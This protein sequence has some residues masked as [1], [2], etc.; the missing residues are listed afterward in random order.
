MDVLGPKT[1]TLHAP[2]LICLAAMP[3]LSPCLALRSA[4]ADSPASPGKTV[5][6]NRIQGTKRLI[7]LERITVGPEDHYQGAPH[8]ASHQLVFTRKIDL[9]PHLA[10]QNLSTGDVSEFVPATADS[11][12]PATHPNGMVAFTYFKFNAR[13]DICYRSLSRP[14]IECLKALEGEKDTP[15]WRSDT[16]IGFLL[17]EP[18]TD[19]KRVVVQSTVSGQSQTLAQGKIWQPHSRPG[20]RYLSYNDQV[21]ESAATTGS[22]SK[23]G[24][25]PNKAMI[26]KDLTTGST[27]RV[28]LAL[29]GI[30]GFPT[31]SLDDQTLY[32]SHYLNDSNNDNVIDGNDN[33]ILFRL[34]ISK[35]LNAK[36]NELLFPEQLT[37]VES[38]C[39]FPRPMETTL[40]A[41]CG[42]SGSLGVY[43]LPLSGIVPQDWDLATLWNAHESARNY[44]DRILILN[45]IKYRSGA[46]DE[47]DLTV[48]LFS[49]HLIADD[50]ASA[51]FYLEAMERSGVMLPGVPPEDRKP[52][53]SLLGIWLKARELK[54]T[55]PSDEVTRSFLKAIQTLE[56]QTALVKGAERLK[57][58]VK[59]S[60]K[61]SL[62]QV[63]ETQSILR[64]V[65]FGGTQG[66][67]H[68]LERYF[69]FK[70]SKWTQDRLGQTAKTTPLYLEMMSAPEFTHENRVY[71]TFK[72]L[73]SLK[74]QDLSPAERISQIETI[75]AS[76][77][78]ALNAQDG[79]LLD[80]LKAEVL[81]LKIGLATTSADKAGVYGQLDKLMVS[82]KAD[83]Y[84]RKALYIRAIFNLADSLDFLH[85]GFVA[86]N[87]LKYTDPR[88]TEFIFARTVFS[89]MTLDR[90]YDALAQ[91]NLQ[92]ASNYFF[93]SLSLT[94]DLESHSGYILSMLERKKRA[95]VSKDYEG[96]KKRNMIDDNLKFVEAFLILVDQDP[97]KATDSNYLD[98]ALSKLEGMT[99]DRNSAVRHLLI[100]YCT[101]EKLLRESNG[102]DFPRDLYEKSYR[103]LLLAHELSSDQVRIRASALSNL[104]ALQMRA[105]NFGLA[106]KFLLKRRDLGF[107]S[108]AEEVSVRWSLARSLFYGDRP[109][110]AAEEI[111][112]AIKAQQ[113][114]AKPEALSG[115]IL[116]ERLAFYLQATGDWKEANDAYLSLDQKIAGLGAQAGGFKSDLFQAKKKLSHGFVSFKLGQ[117]QKAGGLLKEAATIAARLPKLKA[118]GSRLIDFDGR[119]IELAAYGFL[120]RIGSTKERQRASERQ[121]ELLKDAKS[122]LDEHE[123]LRIQNRLVLADQLSKSSPAEAAGILSQALDLALAQAEDGE[124]MSFAVYQSVVAYL[125]SLIVQ[126]QPFMSQAV[127]RARKTIDL[128]ERIYDQQTSDQP[129]LD[130]QRT[131]LELLWSAAQAKMTG[132]RLASTQ[133][134]SILGSP[135]AKKVQS[136]L[137]PRWKELQTLASLLSGR[138]S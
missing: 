11:Q 52:F 136:L 133:S 116:Q 80:L 73:Q 135:S 58:L 45:S 57:R 42:F 111:R 119:R 51:R 43:R 104:G 49:N 117:F 1:S 37:S 63:P 124:G 17:S 81:T 98:L 83:Y 92:L 19:Q 134:D 79:S 72:L 99:Q 61:S 86:G 127:E 23:P 55:Q 138:S 114:E 74:E 2:F 91:V 21:S 88:S 47:S 68:P 126:P 122:L 67:A 3:L 95:D 13:G 90:A 28:A 18:G 76:H 112:H 36:P 26:L 93:S 85:L 46:K 53:F 34:P 78:T 128:I 89:E 12:E 56:T 35:I 30:S 54:K 100:G 59:A 48:R 84:L 41:T 20:S 121:F 50:I 10:I 33:S 82:T 4:N 16:E 101:L 97:S 113:S 107:V 96:M 62:E 71:Y 32:F 115:A 9:A 60:L 118:G 70:L 5:T 102:Y 137:P 132:G 25:A 15:F 103:A 31:V 123:S 77:Q 69:Y 39:S 29:P 108:P 106:T 125:S 66:R 109:R 22:S 94:D 27:Y 14:T 65:S 75:Q 64:Q 129:Q 38:N 105:Q 130:Y 40:Y 8:P 6:Q 120:S 131:K 7:P 87:W 44:S 24:T 110:E